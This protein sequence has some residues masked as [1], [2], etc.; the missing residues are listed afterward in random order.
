MASDLLIRPAQLSDAYELART[1]RPAD[2]VEVL[3]LTGGSTLQALLATLSTGDEA[4]TALRAGKVVGVWGCGR[5][6]LMDPTGVP[7]LLTSRYAEDRPRELMEVSRN[8]VDLWREEYPLLRSY[9][10][11]RYVRAQRWLKWLGFTLLPAVPMGP[12]GY[13]FH[14]FELR[15]V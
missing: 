3:S 15:G 6:C 4:F 12:F 2:R 11:A 5:A 1:I 10:D 13:P 8:T 7:W 9:V 14:P